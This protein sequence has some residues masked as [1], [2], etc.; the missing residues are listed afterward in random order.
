MALILVPSAAPTGELDPMG[1]LELC[2]L[3]DHLQQQRGFHLWRL[4]YSGFWHQ[5]CH[6]LLQ[7]PERIDKLNTA[8]CVN[9]LFSNAEQ[10][11]ESLLPSPS[12]DGVK[13]IS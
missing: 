6:T 3:H 7:T 12:Q 9:S 11:R 13:I 2:Q 4:I 10:G 5:K 8:R 1:L